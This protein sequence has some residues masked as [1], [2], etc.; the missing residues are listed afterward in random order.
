V[1][2]AFPLFHVFLFWASTPG[3]VWSEWVSF[4]K[5]FATSLNYHP[6]FEFHLNPFA[7]RAFF[8]F[9]SLPYCS[10]QVTGRYPFCFWFHSNTHFWCSYD[11]LLRPWVSSLSSRAGHLQLID[12]PS[13]V[14]VS[15]PSR[16]LVRSDV[17]LLFF[18]F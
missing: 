12:A 8:L 9:Q 11:N 10:Y 7:P 1:H 2:S 17:L 15:L 4:P 5:S 14:L 13:P 3:P 6:M 16:P 18:Q